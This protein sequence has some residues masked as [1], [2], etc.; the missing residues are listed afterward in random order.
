MTL[1]L[2][3]KLEKKELENDPRWHSLMKK[4]DVRKLKTSFTLIYPEKNLDF[5]LTLIRFK[6]YYN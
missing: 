3:I 6:C 1:Y 2:Y 5:L 4:D